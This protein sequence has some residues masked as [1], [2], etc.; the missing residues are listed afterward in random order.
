MSARFFL[1]TNI[2]IY[3]FDLGAPEK[4]DRA[5]GL[6]EQALGGDGIISTQVVQEFLNVALKKFKMP[7][8]TEQ[9]QDYFD[10]VLAP[11]CMVFPDLDLYRDALAIQHRWRYSFYDSLIVASAIRGGCDVL[12]SEDLQHGHEIGRLRIKCP[13]SAGA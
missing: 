7:M 4:R 6:V 13:F 9:A 8:R 10:K 2:V 3:C 12:F 11:L 5:L 1:D